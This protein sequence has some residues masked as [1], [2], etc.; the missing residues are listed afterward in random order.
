MSVVSVS[1][2]PN[3]PRTAVGSLNASTGEVRILDSAV[4]EAAP[5]SSATAGELSDLFRAS[6]LSHLLNNP[7]SKMEKRAERAR[8]FSGEEK[9]KKH[10]CP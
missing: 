7:I 4:L 3:P 1:H 6:Q 2:C 5:G 9:Q 10:S 8:G